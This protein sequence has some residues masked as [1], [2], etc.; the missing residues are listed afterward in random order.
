[1]GL[2]VVQRKLSAIA[3]ICCHRGD[4]PLERNAE[5]AAQLL[6]SAIFEREVWPPDLLEEADRVMMLVLQHGRVSDTVKKMDRADLERFLIDAGH[7]AARFAAR[8]PS[9]GVHAER[10]PQDRTPAQL[11]V[12]F[13]RTA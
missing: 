12:R 13:G 8:M 4:G 3:E 6:W 1:M 2:Y 10:S 7:L 11:G 5:K 9:C